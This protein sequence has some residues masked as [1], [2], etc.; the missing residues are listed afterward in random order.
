MNQGETT[1]FSSVIFL[2][3]VCL[4]F[5]LQKQTP[6]PPIR[7]YFIITC[8]ERLFDHCS[9]GDE[10]GSLPRYCILIFIWFGYSPD[11][12]WHRCRG[13]V[14]QRFI[15]HNYVLF[16]SVVC[17]VFCFAFQSCPLFRGE[18][19]WSPLFSVVLCSVVNSV[20]IF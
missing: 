20:S 9:L 15:I 1:C 12:I 13:V 7:Y 4:L 6:P 3:Q 10:L 17:V 5:K 8:Y 11:Q 14:V 18:I 2:I 19:L 16:F